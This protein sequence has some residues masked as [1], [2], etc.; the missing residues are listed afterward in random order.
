MLSQVARERFG[1]SFAPGLEDSLSRIL[2]PEGPHARDVSRENA[3][4]PIRLVEAA[5]ASLAERAVDSSVGFMA[6]FTTLTCLDFSL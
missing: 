6:D 5:L 2:G 1:L 4:L 3:S